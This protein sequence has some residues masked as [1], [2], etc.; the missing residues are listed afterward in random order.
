MV[1]KN[2]AIIDFLIQCDEI[3]GSSLYF[4]FINAKD[5]NKQ[6]ITQ[7]NDKSLNRTYIDGSVLKRYTFTVIAFMS[8]APNPIPKVEGMM[9]ENVR[10]LV[11]VQSV[12]DWVTQQNDERNFP[13]F[14]EECE[15]EEIQALS[16][17]P[18]L[19]GIDNNTS[20][21]LAKYSLTIRVEYID[22]TKAVW[23]KNY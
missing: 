14:G 15:I 7:S 10:D 4:N 12:I 6:I 22:H 2:Q 20:P 3:K 9:D 13:D 16:E 19:D 21:P 8:V 11:D 5:T 17:N 1:N 18:N 23:N